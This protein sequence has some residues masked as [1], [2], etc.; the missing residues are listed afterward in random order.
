MVDALI[1]VVILYGVLFH[2]NRLG[3]VVVQV[4]KFVV[5]DLNGVAVDD[6]ERVV[7]NDND[8][9]VVVVSI[10]NSWVVQENTWYL[11]QYA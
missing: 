2:E 6:H 11:D 5:E 3:V 1:V 4:M 10:R 9:I 7:Q 8:L